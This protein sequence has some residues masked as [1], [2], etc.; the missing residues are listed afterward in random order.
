MQEHRFSLT[1]ILP[2]KGKIVDSVLIRKN[3]RQWKPYSRIFYAVLMKATSSS[4]KSHENARLKYMIPPKLKA[5][6]T[7]EIGHRTNKIICQKNL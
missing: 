1:R 6:Y 2:Y 3:R 4:R 7:C 5:K